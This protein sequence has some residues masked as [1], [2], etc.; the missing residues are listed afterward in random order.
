MVRPAFRKDGLIGGEE[1]ADEASADPSS[2]CS[3]KNHV[4]KKRSQHVAGG[5]AGMRP[6]IDADD[7]EEEDAAA[8]ATDSQ[9]HGTLAPLKVEGKFCGQSQKCS[10]S[11]AA[12]RIVADRDE[13]RRARKSDSNSMK[14][15]R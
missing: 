9:Q 7:S 13:V 2:C 14:C 11:E 8:S 5:S 3:C 4:K 6:L 15:V 10:A 12:R 1:E